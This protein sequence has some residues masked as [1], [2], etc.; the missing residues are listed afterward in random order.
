LTYTRN[1]A[2]GVLFVGIISGHVVNA[3]VGLVSI[4]TASVRRVSD[5]SFVVVGSAVDAPQGLYLVDLKKTHS[6]KDL[7]RSV[8][9]V[10][11][12]K[13]IFSR[14]SPISFPRTYGEDKAGLS[15]AIFIP[16]HNPAFSP[17]PGTKPP[18]IVWSH[19]GPTSHVS[20]GLDLKFQYWTSRG[21]AFAAVN[22]AGSTGYGRKY[23]ESLNYNWGIKDVDDCA[24]CVAYLSSQGLVDGTKVGIVGESAGGYTVLNALTVYPSLF[25]AGNSKYGISNLANLATGTHKFE[26]HYL[27]KLMFPEGTAEE[28][29]KKIYWERSPCNNASKIESPLLILQGE[30]DRVVPLDQAKEMEKVLREGGKDVKLVVFEGE[31]HG[32]RK[33]DNVRRAF[34]E[35]EALWR[36]TLL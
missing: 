5:N 22:Y 19:G 14:S 34:E 27:F 33:E 28:E 23:V 3:P 8:T 12:P 20:P 10:S 6:P 15:H 35:E 29:Q 9:S 2:S 31:G 24:S 18:L 21:Y 1:G 32:F 26:S 16:P 25:A 30:I 11:L 13:S 36:R 17:T 7:I 4:A